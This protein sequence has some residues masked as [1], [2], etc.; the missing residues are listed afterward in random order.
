MTI[1]MASSELR[2]RQALQDLAPADAA[3]LEALVG[4]AQR[5]GR[6][7]RV[8]GIYG[9]PPP[10]YG[11]HHEPGFLPWNRAY[12]YM[13]E[14]DVLDT[15]ATGV[16]QPVWNWIA[17]PEIPG[18]YQ[19]RDGRSTPLT[20]RAAEV[21]PN[22]ETAREVPGPR[23]EPGGT[24]GGA[25]P[26]AADLARVL[27]LEDPVTFAAALEQLSNVVHVWVGGY[28]GRISHAAF[29][30]LFWAHRAMVDAIWW[31]WQQDHPDARLP[32][33][34]LPPF[35]LTS[36]DVHDAEALGYEYGD[37]VLAQTTL[38]H[39]REPQP[40]R[41]AGAH[42]DR[43]AED[44]ALGFAHYATTFAEIIASP[45]TE[46]PLTIGIFGSWGMGKSTLLGQIVRQITDTQDDERPEKG[47][48][49]NAERPPFVHVVPFNAWDYNAEEA[50][51]PAL[52]RTV[53]DKIDREIPWTRWRR[54][55][56][57]FTR[58]VRREWRRNRERILVTGVLLLAAA[59]FAV[60]GLDL[61]PAAAVSG[62]LVLGV[63]GV[64]K[65]ASDTAAAPSSKWLASLFASRGYGARLPQLEDIREDLEFLEDRLRNEDGRNRRVLIL[66]DDLDRCEPAQAVQVLQAVNRLLD[67]GSF[68]VCMGIDARIVTAAIQEHYGGLLEKAGATG[69]E[70]LDKIVQIPFRIPD[71]TPTA[72][73]AFLAAHLPSEPPM[74][75]R[76]E[77][78]PIV[79]TSSSSLSL[80]VGSNVADSTPTSY[81]AASGTYATP[82]S[83]L[84]VVGARLGER[85]AFTREEIK[86]FEDLS[87]YLNPNPRKLKR[88]INVYRLVRTLAESK[89]RVP[90][91][92]D[93]AR[94]VIDDP[95]ATIRWL[96]L[97]SQW[98]Y[99]AR[100][101][102]TEGY[103]RERECKGADRA[104]DAG[105]SL[106]ELLADADGPQLA[107][108]QERYDGSREQLEDFARTCELRWSALRVI[109]SYTVNF[110][111]AVDDEVR[112]Q[113]LSAA[114]PD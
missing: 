81:S 57:L 80:T 59:V 73:G 74:P 62:F 50:I 38:Q 22:A 48:T 30:P 67:R 78:Q 92:R 42:N 97:S 27:A 90:E 110:N 106:A 29:D 20:A 99:T 53:M 91:L 79:R 39:Q 82:H 9:A 56:T 58:N 63:G 55:R 114:A 28:M 68:I 6:Y 95:A 66:I 3:H 89:A 113:P 49:D 64:L 43:A 93:D 105:P 102:V 8:A 14:R 23:R 83:Q 11:I 12:L 47:G 13:F 36:D 72:L 26:S 40:E 2:K 37:V 19:L 60:I 107:V 33:R 45:H 86:A 17:Q 76:I 77:L 32:E 31:C 18:P 52:V 5:D 46:P 70:Y 112:R 75:A 21:M 16:T 1:R 85:V 7:A 25:L 34:E 44:D 10:F 24:L 84:D 111:P 88:V 100:A 51:W 87:A 104:D 98:P 65:V 61:S 109:C 94:V 103:R 15:D 35:E 54:F 41:L 101:V 69:Y 108:G 71:P 96:V 4:A